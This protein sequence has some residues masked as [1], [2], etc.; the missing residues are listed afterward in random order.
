MEIEYIFST[1]NNQEDGRALLVAYL[2]LVPTRW[3]VYEKGD[4]AG[5]VDANIS[6]VSTE[7]LRNG[8]CFKLALIRHNLPNFPS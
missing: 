4:G 2:P 3:G 8:S 5:E 7:F 6:S 1:L